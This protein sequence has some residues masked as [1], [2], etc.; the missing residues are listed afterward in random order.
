MPTEVWN[1]VVRRDQVCV[2]A[3][4]GASGTCSGPMTV[5]HFWHRP[6]GVKGK[7]AP[8]D[9]YHCVAAC[10]YHN[11]YAPP[12]HEVRMATREYIARYYRLNL[13]KLLSGGYEVD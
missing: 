8:H 3:A 5:D 1:E 6:G 13:E 9:R 10:L 11:S 12:S 4:L 2:P 7:R